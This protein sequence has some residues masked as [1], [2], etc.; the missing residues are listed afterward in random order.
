MVV[1]KC[2]TK[3]AML[4]S[5]RTA[6]CTYLNISRES[7][8]MHCLGTDKSYQEDFPKVVVLKCFKKGAMSSSFGRAP[9]S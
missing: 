5:F 3:E 8:K 1:T 4:S 9:C 2:S 6:P 7:A